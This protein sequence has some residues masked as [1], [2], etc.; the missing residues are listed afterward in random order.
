MLRN[1]LTIAWRN[2]MVHRLFS[3][4]KLEA[5]AIGCIQHADDGDSAYRA[6]VELGRRNPKQIE[7]ISGLAA[8]DYACILQ[9]E[10]AGQWQTLA[11]DG[12]R[13]TEP[14]YQLE[15]QLA[16]AGPGRVLV[17]LDR[18]AENPHDPPGQLPTL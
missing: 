7:V 12:F 1:Y 9:A 6:R 17:L 4:I 16:L 3:A 8:G 13:I 11:F 15:G 2:L 18:G 5:T 10:L 14:A